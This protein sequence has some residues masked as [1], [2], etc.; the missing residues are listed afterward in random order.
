MSPTSLSASS[1]AE[2]GKLDVRLRWKA[3]PAGRP[4]EIAIV[5]GSNGRVEG[6]Q[7]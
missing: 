3:T 2:G 4:E 7:K 5:E 1:L 6:A